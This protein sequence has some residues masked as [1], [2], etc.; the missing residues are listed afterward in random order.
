[1]VPT[2]AASATNSVIP[3][4]LPKPRSK[5]LDEAK[6]LALKMGGPRSSIRRGPRPGTKILRNGQRLI[7]STSVFTFTLNCHL[8]QTHSHRSRGDTTWGRRVRRT[9]TR[10]H[11]RAPHAKHR[12]RIVKEGEGRECQA[13]AHRTATTTRNT[14]IERLLRK[15]QLASSNHSYNPKVSELV[16]GTTSLGRSSVELT[17]HWDLSPM[18]RDEFSYQKNKTTTFIHSKYSQPRS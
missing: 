15:G 17:Q 10:T 9:H 7:E 1:M 16:G 3:S 11:T 13:C 2:K 12:H 18:T 14:A 5:P 6:S 4:P 8:G